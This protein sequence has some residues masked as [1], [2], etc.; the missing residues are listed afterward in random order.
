[1]GMAAM[2]PGI[3][4]CG[5]GLQLVNPSVAHQT[6]CRA[7]AVFEAPIWA[8]AK[9][10]PNEGRRLGAN[11]EE[12]RRTITPTTRPRARW[13]P[14]TSRD[15]SWARQKTGAFCPTN[16]YRSPNPFPLL[17]QGP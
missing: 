9:Y 1:M 17:R 12:L 16:P 11:H 3:R 10:M 8:R 7:E 2:M 6:Y 13:R 15:G 4:T 14:F 5:L